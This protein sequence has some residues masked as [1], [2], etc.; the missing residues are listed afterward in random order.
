MVDFGTKK[1]QKCEK[2][3]KF[4]TKIGVSRKRDRKLRN[5]IEYRNV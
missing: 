5:T 3:S 4:L 2:V 1:R